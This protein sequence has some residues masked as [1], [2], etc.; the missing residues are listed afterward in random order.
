MSTQDPD[1]ESSTVGDLWIP[2]PHDQA[3]LSCPVPTLPD[4][5]PLSKEEVETLAEIAASTTDIA[6]YS[7]AVVRLCQGIP[8]MTC[9]RPADG[10]I[11]EICTWIERFMADMVAGDK[12]GYAPLTVLVRVLVSD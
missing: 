8:G 11:A 1:V 5:H 6:I 4:Y 3:G 2:C 12:G 9:P 10:D 7:R